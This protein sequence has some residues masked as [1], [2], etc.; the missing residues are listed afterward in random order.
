MEILRHKPGALEYSTGLASVAGTSE[1]SLIPFS[2]G[3]LVLERL[4]GRSL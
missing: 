4:Q 2:G 3:V 1:R